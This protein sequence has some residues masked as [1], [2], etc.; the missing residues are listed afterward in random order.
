MRSR[1]TSSSPWSPIGT[2]SASTAATASERVLPSVR[3]RSGKPSASLRT[4]ASWPS[5]P[6]DLTPAKASARSCPFLLPGRLL[7]AGTCGSSFT[8]RR[9]DLPRRAMHVLPTTAIS[10]SIPVAPKEAAG[11]ALA[12]GVGLLPVHQLRTTLR[13]LRAR[14]G[15]RP[16]RVEPL[17][18][19]P[20]RVVPRKDGH[21]E[22]IDGFKRLDRAKA[23]G[24]TEVPVVIERAAS[25]PEQKVAVLLANAPP[26][27]LTPM[28]EA[29]VVSS[30]RND[31]G[32]SLSAIAGLCGR[33]R[34][35]VEGRLR[36][37]EKLS[38]TLQGLVDHGRVRT[39]LAHALCALKPEDQD[40]LAETVERHG[41]K[42][43]E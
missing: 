32:L 10:G 20:L 11:A 2:A 7:C 41:L 26:R 31:D 39:T 18:D 14:S 19:L 38:P 5:S 6:S 17:V 28:D 15:S 12:G 13:P 30:L 21:F 22:V 29:R 36:L 1:S 40:S 34:Y 42:G 3:R 24:L 8:P 25:A 9:P 23:R 37:G 27:T 16:S 35:W 43:G 33:K 4:S